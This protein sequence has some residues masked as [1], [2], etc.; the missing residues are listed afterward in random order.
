MGTDDLNSHEVPTQT[1]VRTTE[2]NLKQ[3]TDTSRGEHRFV[4]LIAHSLYMSYRHHDN[5]EWTIHSAPSVNMTPS[6]NILGYH[7][8]CTERGLCQ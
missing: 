7:Q 1:P 8:P 4:A 2:D 5:Q 6:R 3:S